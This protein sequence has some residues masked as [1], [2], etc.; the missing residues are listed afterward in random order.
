MLH[1]TVYYAHFPGSQAESPRSMHPEAAFTLEDDTEVDFHSCPGN[2][3]PPP[4][5]SLI[6]LSYFI[7]CV[8]HEMSL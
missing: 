7:H 4:V 6:F 2:L 3:T 5:P 8:K 1:L